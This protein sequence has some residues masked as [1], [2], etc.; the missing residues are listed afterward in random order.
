MG[1]C[2]TTPKA[3]PGI[4]CAVPD[5]G[6]KILMFHIGTNN[7]QRKDENGEDEFAPGS[8]ILHASFHQTFNS[9]PGVKCYSIYPS[10]KQ[11]SPD[12]EKEDHTFRVFKL[13]HDIPICESVSPNSSYR[14]HSMND[15]E[16]EA[17]RKR[18]EDE[19]CEFMDWA[20]KKEGREFDFLISHH[21]FTNAMTGAQILQRRWK[22]G[23]FK[24]RHFNFVHGT[25]LKM[26]IKEMDKD[27][28]YP[29]RFL[30]LTQNHGCFNGISS[31]QGIWV[32][33]EDYIHKFLD[34]FPSYPKDRLTFS[35]IGV[36]QKIFCPKGTNL[37]DVA[38]YIRDGDK[39]KYEKSGIKRLVTFVGKFADW[40]RLDV[41][42]RAAAIYEEKFQDLGTIIIGSGPEEAVKEYEELAKTLQLKRAFFIGAQGQG[43]LAEIFSASELGMFPSYKEPFGMVFIECMACGTPTVGAKSGG[44]TEFITPEV[45]V[46]IEEEDNWKEEDG[47]KKLGKKLSDVVE[48]ALNENWKGGA[49]GQACTKLVQQN[50]STVVQCTEMLYNMKKWGEV[51]MFHI[52]TNNWQRQ[53]EFAPGSGILHASFHQTFNKIEGVKCYSI[54]PSRAQTDPEPSEDTTFKIFKLQ[55][56]IPICESASTNSSYRWHSMDD[57]QFEAYRKR[58]EDEVCAYM[59]QIEEKEG[60]QFDFLVTHHA[61]TNAMTGAQIIDRRHK[62]GKTSLKHFNFVHGTA[63]KMYIKEM[64]KDPE[65]PERFLKLARDHSVFKGLDK[66]AGIWVNSEDYI[67]KFENCFPEY[68]R[69]N[70]VF[71]R[72]GVNQQMF[73]PQGTQVKDMAQHA[74]AED[75]AK[76]TACKKLVTFVGKFADWKRIDVVL[77]AA[78]VYEP[79]FGDLGTLIIGTGPEQDVKKYE[80]MSKTLQLKR[81]FFLGAQDQTVLAQAFSASE[82]GMFPSYKE[83]FGMVFIECMACGTPTVGANSGGPTEFITPELGVLIDEDEGWREEAGQ[84]RLG[85]ALAAVVEKALNENWKGG[86]KGKACASVVKE[87]YSTFSQ[88]QGMLANMATWSLEHDA[89]LAKKRKEEEEKAAAE[90]AEKAKAEEAK[91]PKQETEE[92][93]KVGCFGGRM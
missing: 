38:K 36:N 78:K 9:M 80:E 52:G 33:S 44:P 92:A 60:R 42:L 50:Y 61:F 49:R 81:T 73:T 66:T 55:H 45:G 34:C 4:G 23:K 68:P 54:Y 27:P 59:D 13:T 31:T 62:E 76:L 79:K 87:K 70:L 91:A 22:E 16:F 46:L 56:D 51:M 84:I 86:E 57:T 43:V 53:G 30:P 3:P 37:T 35:R 69:Q 93:P 2:V 58:L 18:L 32:N 21:A 48:Q 72:I 83:P 39:E 1:G 71:S 12:P 5:D 74:K 90:A 28:E 8:G 20:E 47:S 40:K 75:K 6:A 15:G 63:L 24:L 77:Q 7:W 64:E 10:R 11:V 82:L 41:V 19:I 29:T 67:N 89:L 88:C 65:Y 26:Y 17:Y 14:W 25:A 85:T